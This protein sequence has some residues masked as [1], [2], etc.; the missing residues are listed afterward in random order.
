MPAELRE[1]M[2]HESVETTMKY[3]VGV[4]ADVT[5]QKLWADQSN[6]FG[7]SGPKQGKQQRAETWKT[8][9]KQVAEI[10]LEP[11]RGLPL[12]GF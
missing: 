8:P 4:N 3:Y 10:G 9:G 11:V 6:T 12:T 2:W 7:N 5:A 1:L